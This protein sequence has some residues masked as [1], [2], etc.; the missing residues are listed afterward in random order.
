MDTVMTIDK[1]YDL[2]RADSQSSPAF[3]TFEIHCY[4]HEKSGL[5]S[6]DM[7]Q[8]LTLISTGLNGA[9]SAVKG[10]NKTTA[11]QFPTQIGPRAVEADFGIESSAVVKAFP[12]VV[13]HVI[14]ERY[15]ATQIAERFF[16]TMESQCI[17]NQSQC[18]VLSRK[19]KQFFSSQTS[20]QA[21]KMAIEIKSTFDSSVNSNKEASL[22]LWSAD[23][24]TKARLQFQNTVCKYLLANEREVCNFGR[25]ASV[26]NTLTN[27]WGSNIENTNKIIQKLYSKDCSEL[28]TNFLL[29]NL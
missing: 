5:P 29:I 13:K 24:E 2:M 14:R 10:A 3:P 4:N 23:K 11:N 7:E 12:K 26:N 8:G 9:V 18:H 6:P 21:K 16:V 19:M 20:M 25:D 27:G 17:L 15:H 22:L 28:Q 1:H